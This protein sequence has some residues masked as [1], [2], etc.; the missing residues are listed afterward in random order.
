MGREVEAG[1]SLERINPVISAS[2]ADNWAASVSLKGGTPGEI[3]SVYV[4][5]KSS[6]SLV[7]IEPNPFSPDSDGFED[8]AI[9]DF[10]LPILTGF[11]TID[12]YDM[13]GRKIKRLTNRAPVAQKGQ[14]IW[15]GKNED[16]RVSRIGLYIL[17]IQI[18]DPSQ[19][20]YKEIKKTVVLTKK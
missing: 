3:N 10:S 2:L 5:K 4:E 13:A 12:I 19:N 17:I 14:F 16:G 18:F 7:T 8:V 6:E 15:D 11:L 20:L 1:V 9:I